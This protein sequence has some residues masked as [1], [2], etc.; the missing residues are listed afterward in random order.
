MTERGEEE[1]PKADE[2]LRSPIA[3][4]TIR[5]GAD[6]EDIYG[7]AQPVA[8]ENTLE[9]YNAIRGAVGLLDFSPLL[10]VDV[11]GPNAKQILNRLHSRDLNKVATG[12]IA[13]GTILNEHGGIV[14]DSTV[15]VRGED[16]LRVVGSPLMPGEVIP[17]AEEHGLRA[18]ERRSELAHL[19][20]QG[21]R[22]RELLAELADI[23]VSNA[24][25]PYYTFKESVTVAGV[26]DVFITRMGYTA[27]LGYELFVPTERAL[28]VYDKLAAAGARYGFRP[29]GVAAIMMVRLEAGMVM[30]G[31]EYDASISPWEAALGWTV[32]LD[33]GDFR[34][35]DAV[36][37]LRDERPGRI[38]SVVLNGGE[39]AAT[40]AEL[41]LLDGTPV[42][43]VT[44]S[45]PSPY[46]GGK[47][48]G[49]A[50]VH[51]DYAAPGTAVVAALDEQQ[52]TGELVSTPVYDPERKR[53]KS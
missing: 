33:K 24:A 14:D 52:I 10:K 46:L 18:V 47:T 49:L 43:H 37:A 19:N 26:D 45:M 16:R 31:F 50:R 23:D 44:M 38:I 4:R 36:I 40:G 11:D 8:I 2:L 41:S 28:D 20:I 48:L 53:V 3:D 21:P 39:D 30:G 35:R 5:D 1:V 25:F 22:S 12:R 51:K 32:N 6:V 42:G 34:G 7:M 9:E 13:Y 27:E 29:V 15:M 17:F